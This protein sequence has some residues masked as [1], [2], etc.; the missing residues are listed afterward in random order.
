M[1]KVIGRRKIVAVAGTMVLAGPALAACAMGPT[2]EQ[3]AETDGAAG[4][5]N[6]EEVQ[7]A[8]K[9]SESPSE[10]ERRVNEIYEGDSLVLILSLIHI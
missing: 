2:Y 10:F 9:K 7:E 8:F 6:L 1:R 3:W 5:I 4:R